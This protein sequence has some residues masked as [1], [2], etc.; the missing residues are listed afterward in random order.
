TKCRPSS[1]T[2][3]RVPVRSTSVTVSVTGPSVTGAASVQSSRASEAVPLSATH[4]SGVEPL[5]TGGT[6]SGSVTAKPTVACPPGASAV[7]TKP[8]GY[9]PGGGAME[10]VWLPATMPGGLP[11]SVAA[12]QRDSATRHSCPCGHSLLPWQVSVT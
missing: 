5:S 8:G 4:C 6:V 11:S 9:S 2:S 1:T 7:A 10:S 3:A 12:M